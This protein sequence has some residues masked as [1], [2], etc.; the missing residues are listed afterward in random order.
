VLESLKRISVFLSVV[1]MIT[2]YGVPPPTTSLSAVNA[3][4]EVKDA[5]VVAPYLKINLPP[6][7]STVKLVVASLV[8]FVAFVAFVALV[9]VAAL[10]LMLMFQ[11]PDAPVPVG[12]GTSVPITS[13]RFVRAFAAVVAPVPP[14]ATFSVPATVTAPV[15]VVLGVS[16]V[17]PN[18]IEDT[19]AAA[20]VHVGTPEPLLV[21]T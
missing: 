10:P 4:V 17:V 2:P 3:P 16:P 6:D 18:E 1:G 19:L 20:L 21:N 15:V 5:M 7:S 11:V 14:L 9:A 12:D 13:P 8:A